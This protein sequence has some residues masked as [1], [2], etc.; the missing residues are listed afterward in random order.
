VIPDKDRS[1]DLSLLL[2]HPYFG[3][4]ERIVT[5]ALEEGGAAPD[6]TLASSDGGEVRLSGLRGE[7]VVLY[8]YPK[9][10]TPGC[11]TEAC[12]IR[13]NW[14]LLSGEGKLFGVSP[15]SL[16]SHEKFR[17]KHSLPFPL[18]A[19]EGHAVSDAY[20]VWGPK[21]FMGREYWA[22]TARRSSSTRTVNWRGSF[23]R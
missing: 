21:K 5:T 4:R 16:K 3:R 2:R 20:G 15:D 1:K 8:W 17:D 14:Q 7:W 9:D 11:T 10:D 19:D 23:R 6:F 13:D 22:W 12:E 18:L